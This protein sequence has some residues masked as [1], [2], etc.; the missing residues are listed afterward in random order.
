MRPVNRPFL[1]VIFAALLAEAT[2]N[3]HQGV[4]TRERLAR[5][6]AKVDILLL[7][8]DARHASFVSTGGG[9]ACTVCRFCTS[10][11]CEQCGSNAVGEDPQIP[12]PSDRWG[13]R[14]LGG[15]STFWP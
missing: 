5:V 15:W 11:G 14:D 9:R 6:E 13:D 1:V 2:W 10:K 12:P 3:I 7:E 8:K 4:E